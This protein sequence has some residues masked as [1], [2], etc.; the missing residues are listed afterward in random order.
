M[1]APSYKESPLIDDHKAPKTVFEQ[2]FQNLYQ[3]LLWVLHVSHD[4]SLKI[5][6]FLEIV[7][8]D[9]QIFSLYIDSFYSLGVVCGP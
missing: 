2:S 7:H 6:Q 8:S 3:L 9:I 4:K 1:L 5:G